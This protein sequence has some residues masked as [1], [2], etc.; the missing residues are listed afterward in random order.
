MFNHM[1]ED[2]LRGRLSGARY[3]GSTAFIIPRLP[4]PG[5]PIP[6]R[7]EDAI[8]R[9]AWSITMTDD[10]ICG[11]IFSKLEKLYGSSEN[12]ATRRGKR[13]K[14]AQK[15]LLPP[16]EFSADNTTSITKIDSVDQP[17][18]VHRGPVS[19]RHH[20]YTRLTPGRLLLPPEPDAQ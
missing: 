20:P 11:K 4:S 17:L 5:R 12:S 19:R 1:D 2:P 6:L 9:W 16:D 7:P 3:G 8:I 14:N 13:I 10:F 18:V 15:A